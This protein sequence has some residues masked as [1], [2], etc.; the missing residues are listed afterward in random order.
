VAKWT[1]YYGDRVVVTGLSTKA[2][3]DLAEELLH[4]AARATVAWFVAVSADGRPGAFQI[5]L[6][7]GAS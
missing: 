1:F 3:D 2:K 5:L 7:P 6:H 4:A